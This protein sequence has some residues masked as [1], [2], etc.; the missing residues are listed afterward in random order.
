MKNKLPP[1]VRATMN[2]SGRQYDVLPGQSLLEAGLSAGIALPFGCA[3][4]SCG[5]CQARL[6]SGQIKKTRN[7]E[8][9]LTEAQK[10]DGCCLLCSTTALT[11]VQIDVLIAASVN[12]IPQQ[13]LQAK[14]CRVEHTSDVTIIAF[15]FVRGK[16]LRFLPGQRVNLTLKCG[17]TAELPIASC[18][19]N[20]QY[21][22]FHLTA[23]TAGLD[24]LSRFSETAPA[25]RERVS[26]S[27]PHGNFTLSASL[28]KPKLFITTGGEF[29]QIQGMIEQVLNDELDVPCCLLWKASEN[30]AHYRSNLCRSWHD[31]FDQFNFV[32]VASNEDVLGALPEQWHTQLAQSEVYLGKKD[33]TIF[34]SLVER[35][36]N[37][38]CIVFPDQVFPCRN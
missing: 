1:I 34:Q 24:Y 36:V 32:P 26:I 12:D 18:P 21:V 7:H 25:E 3:N 2:P 8:F 30:V 31:A 16:A 27:G 14:L 9:V 10:L 37:P 33:S 17:N 6:L 22:E 11:D 35:G 5:D 28:D 29:G 15:K 20:A 23:E 19:C 4:G 38:A 13:Q